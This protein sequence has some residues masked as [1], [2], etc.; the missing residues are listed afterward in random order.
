MA[1]IVYVGLDVH[2]DSI[3]I[4]VA[5]GEGKSAEAWKTVAYDGIRLRKALKSL[6]KKGE[7]LRVCY[8]AGPTGLACVGACARQASIAS[9]WPHLWCQGNQAIASRLTVAMHKS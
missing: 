4:A 1:S 3:T 2:K 9:S 8:E 6:I 5:R 7:E